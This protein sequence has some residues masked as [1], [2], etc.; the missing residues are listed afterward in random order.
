MNTHHFDSIS[1]DDLRNQGSFKWTQHPNMIGAFIAEMD[2]GTAPAVRDAI[3]EAVSRN[4][5]GYVPDALLD[6]LREA[7]C[8]W[9]HDRYTWKVT[10]DQVHPVADVLTILEL[11]VKHF[12]AADS[13]VI[14]LTPTYMPFLTL[15][16]RWGRQVIEVP[17]IQSHDGWDIDDSRLDDALSTGAGLVILCNPGNPTGHVL[18]ADQLTRLSSLVESHNAFVFADEIHAPLIYPGTAHVPY[19][20]LSATTRSHTI[21]A[22]S[23]AKGW[24]IPGLK[25]AQAIIQ[26]S[27]IAAEWTKQCGRA[28]D[29]ASSLGIIANI[30][31]YRDG[32]GWLDEVVSYLNQNRRVLGDELAARIPTVRYTPPQA[33]YLSWLDCRELELGD[34]PW[35][36]FR[37]RAGVLTT[38]GVACGTV[39]AGHL[40]LNFATPRPILVAAIAAMADALDQR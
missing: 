4:A 23:A 37:D 19:A 38:N 40:R 6:D 12:T 10:P 16:G 18:R 8:G 15:P 7:C 2:F 13:A 26:D 3:T 28:E 21:T 39:G 14:V 34:T 9:Q 11:T 22:T 32:A 20:S 33:T 27:S 36:F 35:E 5:F 30:A 29:G 24:N 25:C 17:L 31:A 1:Q